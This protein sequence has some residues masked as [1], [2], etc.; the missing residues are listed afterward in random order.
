MPDSAH[1]GK[2]A[3]FATPPRL[4]DTTDTTLGASGLGAGGAWWAAREKML[5][6]EN[7]ALVIELPPASAAWIIFG[8]GMNL[9]SNALKITRT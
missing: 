2:V 5:G 9:P 1:S 3:S 6:I 8:S 4:N 7:R